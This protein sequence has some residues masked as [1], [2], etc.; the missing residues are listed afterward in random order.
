MQA[1]NHIVMNFFDESFTSCHI[2]LNVI[3]T[4]FIQEI[5]YVGNEG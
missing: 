4:Y 2:L 1:V 3:K 5:S